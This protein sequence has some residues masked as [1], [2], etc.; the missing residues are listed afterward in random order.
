MSTSTSQQTLDKC[1]PIDHDLMQVRS[2]LMTLNTSAIYL[3]DKPE[4][5]LD[6][7]I[8]KRIGHGNHLITKSSSATTAENTELHQENF[9]PTFSP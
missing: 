4:S 9:M 2:K 1:D 7:V 6:Q 3:G 5:V 8:W